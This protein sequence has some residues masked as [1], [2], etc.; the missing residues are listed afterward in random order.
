MRTRIHQAGIAAAAVIL[1]TLTLAC[2]SQSATEHPGDTAPAATAKQE[3]SDATP[4]QE[5]T[6]G[7]SA[8]Q[9]APSATTS[10]S[11]SGQ[12]RLSDAEIAQIR[13]HIAEL[14]ELPARVSQCAE[15]NGET[16]P[17]P[18]S[19]GEVQWYVD[20]AIKYADCASQ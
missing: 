3:Q 2:G 10:P 17:A 4:V 19:P 5:Q 7:T 11:P 16:V 20:A 1:L 14:Q 9:P 8:A 18:G 12:Q 15:D 6:A 13:A